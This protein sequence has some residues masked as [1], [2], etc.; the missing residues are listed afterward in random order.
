[1]NGLYARGV[2]THEGSLFGLSVQLYTT[3][4]IVRWLAT[5]T[6]D[7]ERLGAPGLLT[8]LTEAMLQAMVRGGARV[9]AIDDAAVGAD[10]AIDLRG[11]WTFQS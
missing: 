6:E 9:H 7:E 5:T 8:V 3:P 4:S 11:A 2:G 1:M 10:G